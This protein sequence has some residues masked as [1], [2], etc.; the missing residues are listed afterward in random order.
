L[1]AAARALVAERALELQPL[2][3]KL[4][5]QFQARYAHLVP[6]WEIHDLGNDLVNE[7]ALTFDPGSKTKL[8]TYFWFLF[9]HRIVGLL[10]KHGYGKTGMLEG[11]DPTGSRKRIW[12]I[13]EAERIPDPAS[14]EEPGIDPLM[15][16]SISDAW[17]SERSKTFMEII[18]LIKEQLPEDKQIIWWA[19]AMGRELSSG[20]LQRLGDLKG[21]PMTAEAIRKARHDAIKKVDRIR[22]RVR[23][24]GGLESHEEIP[25]RWFDDATVP[26][27]PR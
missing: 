15:P 19:D 2:R 3:R 4:T 17:L 16:F 5:M 6:E 12:S 23:D 7:A 11:E 24:A 13:T 9:E 27:S 26:E 8:T 21:T 14:T 1:A 25:P 18:R 20:D 10:E 22:Q